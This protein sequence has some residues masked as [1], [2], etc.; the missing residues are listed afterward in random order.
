[1]WM[2]CVSGIWDRLQN[3]VK[4][5]WVLINWGQTR[6]KSVLINDGKDGLTWELVA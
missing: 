1:M 6:R 4:K 5:I 2:E 3:I